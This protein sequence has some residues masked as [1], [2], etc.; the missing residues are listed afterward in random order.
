MDYVQYLYYH[1]VLKNLH[2]RM[3]QES[4]G[5][6]VNRAIESVQNRLNEYEANSN[7]NK[8]ASFLSR[9]LERPFSSVFK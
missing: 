7:Q 4:A 9:S 8:K 5:T 2:K 3:D 6:L 1:G